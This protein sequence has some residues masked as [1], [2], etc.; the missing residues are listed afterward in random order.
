MA[1]NL[2]DSFV[3]SPPWHE[4]DAKTATPIVAHLPKFRPLRSDAYEALRE[5][6]LLRRLRPGQR[7]VEAEIARQ[8]GISR[9][10]IREAVRQLEQEDLVEYHPRRGVVVRRLTR[11]AAQ[12]T[13]A[14]RAEL[15]GF[16]ARLAADRIS[17]DEIALLDDLLAG[18]RRRAREGDNDGLLNTDVEFH[19]FIYT[20]A[21]N[22]VLLR[23]WTSLG[24]HAWTLFSGIQ[25]RGYSLS[26]LAERHMPIV[27][28]LRTRDPVASER[29]AKEH[30]L[31]IARNV[32]DHL[33]NTALNLADDARHM[34]QT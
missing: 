28:A 3:T 10:P 4:G 18:M 22:R 33:D 21:N 8:M 5:A 19:R 9:G 13:Y 2:A 32:L 12:D 1:D 15:D 6:I 29:A 20:V 24:P 34:S 23:A 25:V 14:V 31:E 26:D 11:E 17:D 7:I 27:E 30:T 16:A